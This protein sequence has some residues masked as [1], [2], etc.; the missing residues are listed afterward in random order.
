MAELVLRERPS[1]AKLVAA[2]AAVYVIWGSTYLAILYAIETLPPFLMAGVRFLIAGAALYAWAWLRGARRPALVHWKSAL[3]IGALMLVG[4][5]GGVVWSEQRVASG[6][7]ALL[8]ATVP[9]WMVLLE[10]VQRDGTRPD[11]R[12]LFGVA[13]G[14]AGLALL[15]GP[16]ALLGGERVDP[17]G[18][19]ALVLGSLSWAAGSLYSRRAPLPRSPLLGTAME[20]LA[21][22]ALLTLLGLAV[23]EAG[24]VDLDAVSLRSI[25]ALLY[26]IV[27]GSLVGFTAYT[28]LLG[29][30]TP[31]R[32]ST[33]AYVN[34]V[35][36]VLLGWA[37]AGEPITP[38]MA[39][40]A[41]IIVGAV[42]AITG[43]QGTRRRPAMERPETA[44]A[45]ACMTPAE[46]AGDV[47]PP[48]SPAALEPL[49]QDP[50]TPRARA[51]GEN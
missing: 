40:A 41:V 31:A 42:A 13:L 14:L 30:S 21:G 16:N 23:G 46:G 8:V 1:T 12:T 28:W 10:W 18:A 35:V 38:R 43:G 5:N 9:L 49:S 47:A 39:V 19:A 36:A 32:V 11:G 6:L 3:I 15:V 17:L 29:V 7:A 33:Y 37:F 26:L 22:G 45:T 4:G 50:P 48:L 27:F 2:F 20:M 51:A 24:A 25:L 34:P 44:A